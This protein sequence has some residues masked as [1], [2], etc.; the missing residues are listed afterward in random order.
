MSLLGG[1][2]HYVTAVHA[3]GP[4]Q[5]GVVDGDLV[6]A[7][8]GD[9]SLS[10]PFW[11]SGE[12]ALEA[13]ADSI[14]AAGVRHVTGRLLVDASAWDSTTV[15]PTWEVDDLP[16]AYSST[17]G[18]FAVDRGELRVIVWG[19]GTEG[20]PAHASWSP[21]GTPDFV[22]ADLTT[23]P[24]DSSTRVRSSYLPES[25]RIVLTGQVRAGS[26]DT[27]TFALRDPVRQATAALARILAE[28]GV[29]IDGG[30]DVAWDRPASASAD[31]R[32]SRP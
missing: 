5:D 21:V 11:P 29:E 18:A 16:N 25:R 24:A 20:E 6:L 10:E 4:V 8:T 15:G 26:V 12:A 9:P 2:F 14:A 13:L 19:G 31:S 23:A 17:G 3:T 30:W 27:L 7:G 1:D 28:R 22:H 32:P